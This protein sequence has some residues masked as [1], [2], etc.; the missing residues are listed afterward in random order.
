MGIINYIRKGGK[1]ALEVDGKIMTVTSG[2]NILAGSFVDI[3]RSNNQLFAYNATQTSCTGVSKTGGATGSSI[4]V[5]VPKDVVINATPQAYPLWLRAYTGGN[6]TQTVYV[7]EQEFTKWTPYSSSNV[8]DENRYVNIGTIT[9]GKT[10]RLAYG[11]IK[12]DFLTHVNSGD[13]TKAPFWSPSGIQF[14]AGDSF[15]MPSSTTYLYFNTSIGCFEA[16]TLILMSDDTYKRFDEIKIGDKIKSYSF[17]ESK[18]VVCMVE[19]VFTSDYKNYYTITLENGEIIKGS[20]N[21]PIYSTTH[22]DYIKIIDLK[23]GDKVKTDKGELTIISNTISE[24]KVIL[25]NMT[26]E[27]CHNYF[28]SKSNVLAHNA[29]T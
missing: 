29:V 22:K 15:I 13:I 12:K 3:R 26:V 25:Y 5:Y 19:N 8:E 7:D 4:E 24:E 17:E 27:N 6:G 20:Y 9:E 10:V 23:C 16:S 1:K 11:G 18:I 14:T 2:E 21:H 28:I